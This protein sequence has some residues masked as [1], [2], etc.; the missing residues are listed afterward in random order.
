MN[1]IIFLKFL[2]K[3][4]IHLIIVLIGLYRIDLKV[5]ARTYNKIY[6]L[7]S[8]F[9]IILNEILNFIF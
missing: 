4:K 6:Y 8:K 3:F 2:Y 9:D 1:L 5:I 7:F